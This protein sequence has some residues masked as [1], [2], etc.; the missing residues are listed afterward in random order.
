MFKRLD[1]HHKVKV[2][3]T[4]FV[5]A[6]TIATLFHAATGVAACIAANMYWIWAE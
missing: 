5:T 4:I 3:V 6:A 1:H 2:A